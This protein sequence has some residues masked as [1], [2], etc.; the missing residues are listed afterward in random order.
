MHPR[1]EEREKKEGCEGIQKRTFNQKFKML[2]SSRA[3]LLFTSGLRGIFVV[4]GKIKSNKCERLR[5]QQQLSSL[6]FA[7]HPSSFASEQQ[8]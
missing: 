3:K 2:R 4:D 1:I 6:N 7:I 8:L 5:Q